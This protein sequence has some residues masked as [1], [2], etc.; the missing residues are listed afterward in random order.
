M[1]TLGIPGSS[2]TAIL[3]AALVLWGFKP[4]PLFIPENPTLFWGLVASMYM[5]NLMLLVLNLPLVPLF[6]QALRAPIYVLFPV[7]L[8]ISLVGVYSASGSLFD[9]WLLAAFGLGGYLMRKLDYPS[10]PLILGFV[11]GAPLERALRQSL[12]MSDGSLSILVSRPVPALMLS[13]A[14]LILLIPLIG[15]VNSWRL[16]ALE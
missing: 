7:I 11:L 8:G 6:A 15:K 9:V 14:V 2:T 3:L 5:G 10:A 4:G 13:L 16:R 12:M 1:L